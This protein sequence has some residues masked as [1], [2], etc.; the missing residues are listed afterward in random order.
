MTHVIVEPGVCGLTAD[1]RVN[2]VEMGQAEIEID[3]KCKMIDELAKS[4]EQPVDV[5]TV[6]GMSRGGPLLEQARMGKGIHA[7]CPV[8]A[9]ITKAV[10]AA[11]QMALPR[12]A[13]ITF[14]DD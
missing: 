8:V 12:N 3:T 5:Y 2:I 10:E 14:V 7:A 1:I 13:S 11:A 4:L 9:G 6:L